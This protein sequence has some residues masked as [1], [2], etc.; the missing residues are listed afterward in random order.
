MGI[1]GAGMVGA[2]LAQQEFLDTICH[3]GAKIR[4]E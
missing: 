1:V 2:A 3:F 4:I